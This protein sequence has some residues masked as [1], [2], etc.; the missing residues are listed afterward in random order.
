MNILSKKAATMQDLEVLFM[1]RTNV[2]SLRL[3]W[4]GPWL[5]CWWLRNEECGVTLDVSRLMNP[6]M[7]IT[8]PKSAG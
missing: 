6:A 1:S 2:S 7:A 8:T 3:E 5:A 4:N